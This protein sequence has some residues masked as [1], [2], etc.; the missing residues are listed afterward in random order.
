[1]AIYRNGASGKVSLFIQEPEDEV[2]AVR[3]IRIHSPN[4]SKIERKY[5]LNKSMVCPGL[6]A[7]A[8]GLTGGYETDGSQEPVNRELL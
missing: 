8:L 3:F 5:W 4:I 2:A 6:E 7:E 1:M